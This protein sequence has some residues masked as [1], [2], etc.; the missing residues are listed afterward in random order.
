[1]HD[2]KHQHQHKDPFVPAEATI[3]EARPA[4]A[5]QPA[6]GADAFFC[7][8]GLRVRKEFRDMT[9]EEWTRYLAAVKRMYEPDPVTGKSKVDSFT[10]I[11][12]DNADI[13][14]NTAH[15]LPWHRWFTFLYEEELRK[16][17]PDVTIPYWDWTFDAQAPLKSPLFRPEYLGLKT[18][19]KGD[20]DWIVSYPRRHCV[21]RT[22]TPKSVGTFYGR[23]TI[24][25]LISDKRMSWSEFAE[26]FETSP[27][28][29]VHFKIGG[30]GGD[31]ADMA[32]PNDPLFFLHHSMV[33]YVWT[34]RQEFTGKSGEVGGRHRGRRAGVK[35]VLKPFKITV[36]DTFNYKQRMCYTYQPFSGWMTRA[37]PAAQRQEFGWFGQ[38]MANVGKVLA[39]LTGQ[40]QPAKHTLP[41]PLDKQWIDMHGWSPE[42]IKGIEARLQALESMP[43]EGTASSANKTK[44]FLYNFLPIVCSLIL[45]IAF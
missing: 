3:Q 30:E 6:L 19:R 28:G 43:L 2:H 20:C 26:M 31:L 27:H 21:V 11:H 7:P 18:G 38:V 15:F 40:Q 17:D 4:F 44:L 13:A 39:G 14:H 29:I 22:Y 25:R 41:D 42:W 45:L 23:R 37:A 5:K 10:R 16:Y 1:M 36:E 24:D 32:S 33:D 12:L 8:G 35:D 9:W 34:M